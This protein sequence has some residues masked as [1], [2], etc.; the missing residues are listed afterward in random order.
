VSCLR[1]NFSVS[2]AAFDLFSGFGPRERFSGLIPMLQE[3]GDGAFQFG[4]RIKAAPG[5]GLLAYN[6]EPALDQV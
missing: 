3:V 6:A 4:H 1:N 5:D 2:D